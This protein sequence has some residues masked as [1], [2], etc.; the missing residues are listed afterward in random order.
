MSVAAYEQDKPLVQKRVSEETS[1]EGAA[2]AGAEI[3][4]SQQ[5]AD[6]GWWPGNW[7]RCQS[8]SLAGERA[9]P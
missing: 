4:R 7:Q 1:E 8:Q 6:T 2:E 9:H 3:H 5:A